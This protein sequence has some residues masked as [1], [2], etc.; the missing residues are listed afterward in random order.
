MLIFATTSRS[1]GS[2]FFGNKMLIIKNV[3]GVFSLFFNNFRITS[4]TEGDIVRLKHRLSHVDRF[5]LPDIRQAMS[6]NFLLPGDV[7]M[8]PKTGRFIVFEDRDRGYDLATGLPVWVPP[9]IC[10]VA[11]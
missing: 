8:S 2:N 6:R 11:V 5:I 1:S 3:D 9:Q 4:G 7:A 10:K